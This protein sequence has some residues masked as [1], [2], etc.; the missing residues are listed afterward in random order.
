MP[1]SNRHLV[2]LVGMPPNRRVDYVAVAIQSSGRDCKVL[3]L[4]Q[5]IVELLAQLKVHGIGF[6]NHDHATGVAIEAMDDS[7]PCRAAN[8]GKRLKPEC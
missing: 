2:A 1:G 4:D 8:I 7:R 6:G 3:L 5:A